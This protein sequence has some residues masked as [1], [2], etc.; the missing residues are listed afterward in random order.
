MK[1]SS[2]AVPGQPFPRFA[3]V[4]A[5]R[6]FESW[7]CNCGPAALACM[8]GLTLEAARIHL[9][10]FIGRF[11]TNPTMMFGALD[12]I[13][14]KWKC[15]A[16]GK[17]TPLVEWPRLGLARVQ[18]E[19]PWTEPGVPMAARYRHTHWVGALRG[20]RGL[21]IFDINCIGNGS[22]W[23]SIDEWRTTL[24]PW[25]LRESHPRANGCWHLTHAIEVGDHA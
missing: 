18:W 22:G 21:G 1:P 15:V 3:S 25:L 4:D 13:G 2:V 7:G 17:R 20:A 9:P 5:E 6:A 11:Y 8:T 23:V 24:V 12:S 14:V 16:L 19:G 10:D